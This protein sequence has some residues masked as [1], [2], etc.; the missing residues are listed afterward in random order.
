MPVEQHKTD[1]RY[2]RKFQLRELCLPEVESVIRLNPALF[3]EIYW[4]RWINNVYLDTWS[5]TSYQDNVI[6]ASDQRAKIRIRWYGDLFGTVD[7]PTLELKIRQGLLNRKESFP[8][9]PFEM[10]P[11]ISVGV[12][13]QSIRAARLPRGLEHDLLKLDMALINRYQRKYFLS[14]DRDYRVTVDSCLEF[15][16]L[17]GHGSSLRGRWLDP[18][19]IVVELKYQPDHDGRAGHVSQHFPFRL[20]RS[21]KYVMGIEQAAAC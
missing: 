9:E 6:G 10:D 1:Y 17:E 3:R 11:A 20:S 7:R 14:A 16:S 5:R 15:R 2:E 12:I 4:Q 19:L 21:S 8:L 18:S 13:R